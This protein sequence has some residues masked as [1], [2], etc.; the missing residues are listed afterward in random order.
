M[1]IFYVDKDPKVC[2]EMHCDKH[3]VKMIVEYAQL[4]STAHR[5][6]DGTPYY[7][8]TETGRRV[9]RYQLD[10]SYKDALLYKA[11]HINHPS[12]IW[13]RENFENYYWLYDL[14]SHLSDEYT[15]RYS[16]RHSTTELLGDILEIAPD[17]IP[18]GVFTQPPQ[19]MPDEY[20]TKNSIQAYQ[21]FYIGEK[22]PFCNW[23][24]REIPKWFIT[25]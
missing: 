10:G 11:A 18:E 19:C 23:K 25:Q 13:V 5:V 17:N 6:L 21:N 14:F 12:A 2:A 15:Y 22:A 20:K 9:L 4:L 24:N 1:N 16:K 8:L 3:V 7:D